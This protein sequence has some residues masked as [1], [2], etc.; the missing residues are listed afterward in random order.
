[1]NLYPC[2]VYCAM[3]SLRL[4]GYVELRRIDSESHKAVEGDVN[5]GITRSL[6]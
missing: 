4:P 3:H 2:E 5:Q 1:M 6:K